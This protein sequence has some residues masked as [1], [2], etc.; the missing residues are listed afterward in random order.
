MFLHAR[1]LGFD[2][3]ASGAR[4]EVTAPLPALC[5][6]LLEQLCGTG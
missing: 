6:K 3:P 5:T 1:R 2:H 4:I